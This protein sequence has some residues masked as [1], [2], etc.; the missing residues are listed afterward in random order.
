MLGNFPQATSL[1]TQ[2]EEVSTWSG[3]Y[4]CSHPPWARAC[5][6]DHTPPWHP[7]Y[8]F[9]RP[10]ALPQFSSVGLVSPLHRLLS[11]TLAGNFKMGIWEWGNLG[12][13]LARNSVSF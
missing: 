1:E 8:P 3:S 4:G 2:P 13:T 11:V 6:L 5:L 10:Q 7:P 12:L 9:T